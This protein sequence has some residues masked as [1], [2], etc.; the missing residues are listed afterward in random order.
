ML[1]LHFSPQ[2]DFI[3]HLGATVK[4]YFYDHEIL[5]KFPDDNIKIREYEYSAS[6]GMK[7]KAKKIIYSTTSRNIEWKIFIYENPR[8]H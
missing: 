7:Q 8:T 1:L 2:V 3:D 5:I 4:I 6:Y